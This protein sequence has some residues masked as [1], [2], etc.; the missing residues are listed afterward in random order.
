MSGPAATLQ[1]L[2]RVT[3]MGIRFW[4]EAAGRVVSNGLVVE[5]YPRDMPER[6]VVA[7]PNRIGVFVVPRLPG[8]R[9]PAFEFGAGDAAFWRR[10]EPRPYII[11]V[12]DRDGHFQPFTLEQPLPAQGIVVPACL[13]PQS[14][15]VDAVPLFSTPSR[16]V[17]TGMTVVRT[18]LRTSGALVAGTVQPAPASWAVL[19][20]QVAGQPPV[21]GIADRE[22][23]VAVIV[24]YPEP[25]ASP[26]RP[27]SPPY[28]AGQSL[29]DQEWTVRLDA[30][31]DPVVPAPIA[32]DLCRTLNQPPA[33][34]WAGSTGT[35]P[36][37]DQTL[38]YGQELIVRDLFLTTA[39][40]PP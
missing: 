19:E 31:Y 15:P 2:T 34:L 38:R 37:P 8:P 32:P 18:E 35:R 7:H 4:D 11:E 33:M 13:P 40:S 24:P 6:R 9:D 29:W 21:R 39:G 27:T 23:R 30:F 1:L 12:S 17:P 26:A 28:A 3:P 20:V 36:L 16:P 5:V 10:I 25:I 22:G 14:P